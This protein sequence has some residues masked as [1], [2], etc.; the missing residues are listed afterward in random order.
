MIY[1]LL[2][3]FLYIFISSKDYF[4]VFSLYKTLKNIEVLPLKK[5]YFALTA[6]ILSYTS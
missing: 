6:F 4:I 1:R 3:L 2:N 5:L